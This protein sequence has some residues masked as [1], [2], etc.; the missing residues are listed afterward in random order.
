MARTPKALPVLTAAEKKEAKLG[1][2][3]QLAIVN[4]EHGKVVSDHKAATKAHATL[5]KET[6]RSTTVSLKAVEL[7]QKKLEKA[8]VA[9]DAGREKIA[10]KLAALEPAKEAVAA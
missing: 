9:A 6:T 10:A 3:T 7:A 5:V 2:K 1:L 8:T 4:V